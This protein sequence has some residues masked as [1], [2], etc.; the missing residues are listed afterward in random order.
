MRLSSIANVSDRTVS[1]NEKTR[2]LNCAAQLIKARRLCICVH[3]TSV[4]QTTITQWWLQLRKADNRTAICTPYRQCI[5]KMF[6]YKASLS[7]KENLGIR[8]V[9]NHFIVYW[10]CGNHWSTHISIILPTKSKQFTV[11]LCIT[12]V[13]LHMHIGWPIIIIDRV[14]AADVTPQGKSI[15]R[16]GGH[17]FSLFQMII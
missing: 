17:L 13:Y 1:D 14:K 9:V 12:C 5:V 3:F 6:L 8:I 2:N 15:F 7:Y 16:H 11:L 4:A 10:T